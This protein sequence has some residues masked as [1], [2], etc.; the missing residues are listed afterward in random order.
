VTKL[1]G[2]TAAGAVVGVGGGGGD[3][4]AA[5]VVAGG[6]GVGAVPAIIA[7]RLFKY[8]GNWASILYSNS[9]TALN[10]FAEEV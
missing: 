10:T 5:A 4:V 3:S 8:E 2:L 7:S 6:A 9:E 1:K